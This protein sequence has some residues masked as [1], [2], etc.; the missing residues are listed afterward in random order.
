MF[1]K[2]TTTNNKFQKLAFETQPDSEQ[3][4]LYETDKESFRITLNQQ[5]HGCSLKIENSAHFTEEDDEHPSRSSRSHFAI[6]IPQRLAAD[7]LHH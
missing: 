1:A 6:H 2:T 7:E 3:L 5:F 4:F